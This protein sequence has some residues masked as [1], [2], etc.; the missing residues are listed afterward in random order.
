M[1]EDDLFLKLKR[2]PIEYVEVIYND[3]YNSLRD[4]W[5]E[6]DADIFLERY[7][8]TYREMFRELN[9]IYPEQY[10]APVAY[11]SRKN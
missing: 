4:K 5:V 10:Y 8:W 9:G 11:S 2:Q 6:Y 3:W 1:P 7:G